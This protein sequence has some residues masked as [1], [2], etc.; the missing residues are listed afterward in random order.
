M[1]SLS[2]SIIVN[3]DSKYIETYLRQKGFTK[4]EDQKGKKLEYWV[5][6]LLQQKKIDIPDFEDFLFDELFWGKRKSIRVYKLDNIN[7]IKLSKDWIEPLKE[8][9]G[10]DS[11]NFKNI[12]G[13]FVNSNDIRKIAAVTSEENY[14]G[15][16]VRLRILFVNFAQTY[17]ERVIKNT[18]AYIPVEID[19]KR[20]V[21][22]IKAWSR[23][24]LTE[25]Y[26]PDT[27]MDHIKKIMN[28]SFKVTIKHFGLRHKTVLYNMS[29]GLITDIYEKIPAFNKIFLLEDII[30]EFEKMIL[31]ILPLENITDKEGEIKLDEGVLDF[32]DEINKAIEK[33]VVSDYF[34]DVPYEE[35]W[36]MGID[37]IISKIRF[38]DVEHVLTSLSGE[39]S[40]VPVFCTKTFM[41]LKKSMEDAELV[42]KLWIAKDRDRGKLYLKYDATRDEYLGILILSNIRFKE[43][44][45]IMAME[46]YRNY[47]PKHVKPTT[48]QNQRKVV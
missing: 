15:E 8:K 32:K 29:Q 34:F 43:D 30:T 1:P 13:T 36:N 10:I 19:F 39:E 33:L 12:L 44:D 24:G 5:D 48:E 17:V 47:G 23:N 38:N 18:I 28:F 20:K 31:G 27:M 6:E 4:T 45:L 11:L 35:V 26:K 46:I 9:Y 16:L 22:I 14:K 42:E 25:V 41:S 21:M 40:E 3:V 2:P 7:K 37:T